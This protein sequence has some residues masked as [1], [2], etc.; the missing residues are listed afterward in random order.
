MPSLEAF[1]LLCG[2]IDNPVSAYIYFRV[3]REKFP[4]PYRSLC[5]WK[6]FLSPY[7]RFFAVGK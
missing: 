7:R 1:I 5:H 3:V 6:V 4:S 2:G